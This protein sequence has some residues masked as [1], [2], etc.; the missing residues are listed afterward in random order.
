MET[1]AAGVGECSRSWQCESAAGDDVETLESRI[2]GYW[3]QQRQRKREEL[4]ALARGSM[5]L[6]A[7]RQLPFLGPLPSLRLA[8]LLLA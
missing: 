4:A 5:R 1:C 7:E 2:A 3:E 6:R 8:R